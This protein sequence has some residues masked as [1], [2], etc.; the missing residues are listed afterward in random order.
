MS[1]LPI[2]ISSL[3]EYYFMLQEGLNNAALSQYS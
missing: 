2:S 1:F 3:Y